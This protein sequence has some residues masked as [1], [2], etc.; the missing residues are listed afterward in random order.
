[1]V[2]DSDMT[3]ARSRQ[4]SSSRTLPGQEYCE[5]RRMAPSVSERRRPCS[6]PMRPAGEN[7]APTRGGRVPGWSWHLFAATDA[8]W[9]L[10][11]FETKRTDSNFLQ[12]NGR[13]LL[14]YLLL[15]SPFVLLAVW[16]SVRHGLR[17][18]QQLASRIAQR[19][20]DDLQSVGFNARHREL[21]PLE[22]SLDHLFAQ[23]RHKVDRE[24][25]FVQDAAH[26]IRT[27]LAVITAQAHVMARSP[28]EEERLQAQAHL[29]QAIARTSHLAQQLL[30]LAALDDAQRPAPRDLDV[31]QWLRGALAQAAPQAI[32]RGIDL[33]LEQMLYGLMLASGNDAAVAIAEHIGG[34]VPQ[35]VRM[36]N[37]RAAELGAAGTHFSNPNGLPDDT[38]VTTAYDLARIARA[39]M[40]NEAFRR[41]VSTRSA[42]I[43]WAGRTYSRQLRNKN[44]L[45]ETYPG[46]TG[47]KTGFT[48]RAGRCLVFGASRDGMELVGV[49]LNCSDWFDEA[50]RLMDACFETYTMARVLGP[51]MA[52]GKIAVIDGR[53]ASA[54]LCAMQDLRVPLCEGESAQVVLDVPQAVR[55]PGY[56]GQHIGTAQVVVGGKALAS[57]EIVLSEYVESKRLA[58]DVRRVVSRWML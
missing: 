46:A 3:D 5:R 49:V 14:P 32:A 9:V 34:S 56:A 42:Q 10:R 25:A 1:M 45:L 24:R 48:S 58:L 43:P 41:I 8:R 21:K 18:L 54:R 4:F 29:E 19:G 44:R 22:Q 52:A 37:A 26:E 20:Q 30:D 51:T 35:F 36:M 57:C 39:A 53:Q 15:A 38:H 50:A 47:V 23:L 17:P 28:I 7:T 31:A 11:V 2:P 6:S 27:P 55:A 33:T 13:A 12:Y 40:G 16:L